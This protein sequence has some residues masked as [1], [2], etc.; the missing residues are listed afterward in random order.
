MLN[1]VTDAKRVTFTTTIEYDIFSKISSLRTLINVS[2][3]CYRFYDN[4]KKILINKNSLHIDPTER[5]EVLKKLIKVAQSQSFPTEIKSLL[6][7]YALKPNSVLLCLKPFIDKDGLLRVG[8]RL[9]LSDLNYSAKHQLILPKHH[10]L[11]KLIAENEHVRLLHCGSQTLLNSL[12]EPM[13][14]HFWKR[15]Q[16]EYLHGLQMRNKWRKPTTPIK[17]GDLVTIVDD[18]LPTCTWKMG[19]VIQL[20]P[21]KDNEVRVVTIKTATSEIK[22]AI[23]KVCVLPLSDN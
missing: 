16:K 5:E 22:R 3:Y 1:N 6:K 4:T 19:R 9:T 7:N 23:N 13:V 15:W 20:H 2:A 8:G 12:R 14:Q 17:V 11:T 21:G 10:I 18:N